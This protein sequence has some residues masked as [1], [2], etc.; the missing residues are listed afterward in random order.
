[1]SER[2]LTF[3][4]VVQLHS[5]GVVGTSITALIKFTAESIGYRILK[6]R[7]VFAKLWS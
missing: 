1:M 5:S 4:K 7:Y 6:I 3:H 2:A